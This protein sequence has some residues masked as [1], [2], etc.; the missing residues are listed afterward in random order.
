MT[1]LCRSG[2]LLWAMDETRAHDVPEWTAR[3]PGGG[4]N[5]RTSAKRLDRGSPRSAVNRP[6]TP[7]GGVCPVV[8]A[9]PPTRGGP[10]FPPRAANYGLELRHRS[11]LASEISSRCMVRSV[12]AAWKW[13]RAANSR[14]VIAR[15]SSSFGFSMLTSASTVPRPAIMPS[16]SPICNWWCHPTSS[17]ATG[18]GRPSCCLWLPAA[19]ATEIEL[20]H[21]SQVA[22]RSYP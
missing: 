16:A 21:S 10:G 1:R 19:S 2:S 8:A 6:G 15:I 13:I 20:Q 18:V 11:D 17:L 4:R 7:T 5:V 22:L 9:H 12:S 14:F 3:R